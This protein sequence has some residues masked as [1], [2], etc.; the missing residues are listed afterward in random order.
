MRGERL[1]A[2]G[3]KGVSRSVTDRSYHRALGPWQAPAALLPGEMR[4]QRRQQLR[5]QQYSVA[6][7]RWRQN[8]V[9]GAP[10]A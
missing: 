6:R 3:V 4:M 9:H 1:K 5:L 8:G 7:A 10:V 2:G